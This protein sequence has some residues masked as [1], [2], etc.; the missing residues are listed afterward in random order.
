MTNTTLLPASKLNT[1]TIFLPNNYLTA[2][3]LHYTILLHNPA[4]I[5]VARPRCSP[6]LRFSSL[7]NS[8]LGSEYV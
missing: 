8:K 2:G 4:T 1:N 7:L 6:H 3:I 5:F